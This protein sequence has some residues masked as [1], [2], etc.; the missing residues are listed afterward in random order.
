[1]AGVNFTSTQSNGVVTTFAT[2]LDLRWQP[3]KSAN[4]Q[5]GFFLDESSFTNGL[6]P[7]HKEYVPLDITMI[8]MSGNI[9][10]QVIAQLTAVGGIV[11]GG[12]P[13]A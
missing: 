11:A 9:P 1:M 3:G 8:A 7:V 5:V 12:T 10:A 6:E 4:V 13:V 2:I